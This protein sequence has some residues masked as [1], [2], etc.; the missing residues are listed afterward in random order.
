MNTKKT[1]KDFFQIDNP[2]QLQNRRYIGNKY[3]LSNWIFSIIDKE[4]SGNSFADIFA[5][6]GVVSAEANERYKKIILNDFL[7]SN[8]AIYRAFFDKKK[9]DQAKMFKIIKKYN[10]IK[11]KDIKENYFS[12]NLGGKFFSNASAKIIGFV[13]EDIEKN[14]KSFSEKEYYILIASLLYSADRLA[15][16]VGHYDAYVQ[17]NDCIK[18]PFLM[19]LIEP[20]KT[21]KIDIYREDAN[22]L[23]KK[24]KAD[25]VYLDPPYNSRQYSRFYHVLET[26]TKWDKPRL[27]G[28]ALKPPTENVSEYCK[29]KAP[30]KFSDLIQSLTCKYIVVSYNNTYNSRSN[31][32]RNKI[33]LEQIENILNSKG[34]TKIFNKSHRYFNSGNTNFDDHQEYIFITKV[35]K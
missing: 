14:K 30:E 22:L 12:K 2:V 16:T 31:S 18:K 13:R 33:Q 11:S 23:A 35:K 20:V 19:R 5:G 6:T 28:V 27:Y 1:K 7:Y 34:S 29:V 21:N 15:N 4:C 24:I 25:I 32:S 26:L 3:K 9:W 8:Y 10:S 17:N